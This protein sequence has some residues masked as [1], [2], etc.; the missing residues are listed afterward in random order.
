MRQTDEEGRRETE[1]STERES[2]CRR[3]RRRR[4]KKEEDE[5]EGS[6]STAAVAWLP[7]R[8]G[9]GSY[10]RFCR[11]ELSAVLKRYGARRSLWRKWRLQRAEGR[12]RTVVVLHWGRYEIL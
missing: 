8:P 3:R 2:R 10:G 5:E 7:S 1:H 4:E 11:S 9:G 6:E 12:G